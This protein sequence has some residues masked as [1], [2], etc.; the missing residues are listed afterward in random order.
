MIDFAMLGGAKLK[1]EEEKKKKKAWTTPTLTPIVRRK[2]EEGILET[3]KVY[4]LEGPSDD[5]SGCL[6]LLVEEFCCDCE[7]Y[8][9]T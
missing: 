2:P 9:D 5:D 1:M 8:T 7:V 6:S 4:S 3:C